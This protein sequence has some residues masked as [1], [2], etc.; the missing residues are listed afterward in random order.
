MKLAVIGSGYVGLVAGA[1]FSSTGNHVTLVDV[2]QR[3]I[4]LLK[5]GVPP[6]Y[7]PGLKELIDTNAGEDRL[8]FTTDLAPAVAAADVVVLAVGTPPQPDGSVDMSYIETAARQVGAAIDGYTVVVTKSTVP[9][10]THKRLTEIISGETDEEFDYVANPEFL[11][12]GAAIGDFLKPDRVI[13]GVSSERAQEVMRH[14]Y[15][16]FMRRRERLLVMDPASAEL[17]KY[18]CNC[19]LATRISFMNE[20]AK[21]CEHYGANVDN[22]RHGMGLDHRIGPEFLYASLGYGGSCFPKDVKGLISFGRTAN[23]PTRVVEAVHEVNAEQRELMFQRIRHHFDGSMRDRRF[24]LW[25]LAFKAGTDDV[26]ESPAITLIQRLIGAGAGVAVHDPKAM[27]TTREILGDRN[28]TY[29]DDM[30]EVARDADALVVCTEWPVYRT[31]DFQR[32]AESLTSPLVFDGRNLY[33]LHWMA[34]RG[35]TY[36]SIGRPVVQAGPRA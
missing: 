2:D 25:G 11:K 32:I 31:P 19:M 16:P 36:Y 30:Y 13:V 24:G 23:R 6:I 5:Q 3:K 15:S 4:D 17:T 10:G 9:V 21:L 33:D 20:M 35:F 29:C 34:Q 14:L 12:E 18:A 7:E 8:E 1:C 27:D 22:L 26:R 28:V